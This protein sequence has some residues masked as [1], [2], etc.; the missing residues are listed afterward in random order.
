M[1]TTEDTSEIGLEFLPNVAGEAE[2]LGDAGIETFRDKPFA[3]VA[4]ETGQNSRDSRDDV[5]QPVKMTF[6][7]I[8]VPSSEFPSIEDYRKAASRCLAK[9][10][11]GGN[12]KDI[13][14]FNQALKALSAQ[15]IKI[16]RI[17]DFNT[18]GVRG[19]CVE[20]RPFHTLAKSDGMS[21]KENINAGGSFGIGK[22]AAS[23]LSEIQTTFISTRYT[24]TSGDHVLCMGK[25]QFI[26]HKGEDSQELR[27][28]G[29]WGLKKDFMPLENAAD[30]PGWLLR[31]SQGT[32]I[33]S[34]CV[35]ENRADWRYEMAAALLINF[36]TAI[37]RREME[38]EI[39]HSFLKINRSTIEALFADHEVNKAVDQM[40]ARATFD[41]ARLLH[42]C[43]VDEQTV[44]RTLHVAGVGDVHMRILLRENLGY[45]IGIVRNGMY[46]T[47]NLGNFGEPFKRF[48][49]H[50][51][52][53]VIIE[54]AG[55]AEGEWFKRLENPSH[56]DLSAERITDP[57]MRAKGQ[58]AFEDLASQ[59]RQTIRELARSEPTSS[60]ELDELNDFFASD[61]TRTEDEAG[62]ETN[63]RALKPTAVKISPPRPR[64][65]KP[66]PRGENIDIGPGPEPE[67]D[68][69]PEPIPPGPEPG[70]VPRPRKVAEPID[71]QNERNVMADSLNTRKRRL[72]F[73]S[74]VT[75]NLNVGVEASGLNSPEE[76]SIVSAAQ[77]DVKNGE[78]IISATKGQ[79]IILDVDFD[80]PYVGP[81]ELNAFRIDSDDE[82]EEEETAA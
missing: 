75:G 71:L 57:A 22:S 6:D 41:A 28:K 74:P 42:A 16:M 32:S 58:A 59:V 51:E 13:G 31:D 44:L 63:P 54:P 76:L 26:S 34:V 21:V 38:F 25:T 53:A 82:E 29:Y 43:L 47:D 66:Q 67:T 3:A 68:P 1:S 11:A 64:K 14:F 10:K 15:N 70:P 37:Q 33:F 8:T 20:G 12:E 55:D 61:D 78:V 23:A 52:F 5:S 7:E 45:T 80:V 35:R 46:I 50:R 9:S 73:T 36:F 72:F 62:T 40:K 69:N 39:D 49:L 48:P 65:K 81:I 2:G 77:G 56:D 60:M 17:S 18:R 27:R 30:I 24:D 19:P 79:R 4:R